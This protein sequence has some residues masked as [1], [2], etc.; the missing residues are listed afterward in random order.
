MALTNVEYII[1]RNQGELYRYIARH[2][3]DLKAFSD[4]YLTSD[5]C[6]RAFDTTYSRFQFADEEE[7]LDFIWPEIGEVPSLPD[8]QCFEPD[9]AFWIGF[10]YRQLYIKTGV[11]SREL[12]RKL[13]FEKMCGYYPG[14]HTI[15]EDMAIDI[16]CKDFAL[17]RR[18]A[19]Y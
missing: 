6:R 15:D 18:E 17:P 3:Y 14:L 19:Q 1:C 4:A 2:G 16:I 8:G 13:P 12:L 9:V 10:V 11:C 5:F 7:C